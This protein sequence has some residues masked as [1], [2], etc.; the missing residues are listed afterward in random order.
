MRDAITTISYPN[1]TEVYKKSAEN[2]SIDRELPYVWICTP[3]RVLALCVHIQTSLRSQMIQ[4]YQNHT[5]CSRMCL[6]WS[7][8]FLVIFNWDRVS[9]RIFSQIKLGLF[10]IIH[11][12]SC[13]FLFA[14]GPSFAATK[15]NF[16]SHVYFFIW[17][18][19]LADSVWHRSSCYNCA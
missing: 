19:C 15:H 11:P 16:I 7:A 13:L 3:I 12:F 14:D 9:I 18:H 6:S 1:R 17:V 10:Y 8:L 5:K 2:L 4:M